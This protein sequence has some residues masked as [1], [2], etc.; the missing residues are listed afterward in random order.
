VVIE[1]P[2]DYTKK[3]VVPFDAGSHAPEFVIVRHEP[4]AGC[5]LV[6]MHMSSHQAMTR[7]LKLDPAWTVEE[8][9][10]K[11]ERSWTERD[12]LEMTAEEKALGS[13]LTKRALNVCLLATAYGVRKDFRFRP[14]VL[15]PAND[16]SAVVR[17]PHYHRSACLLF[18]HLPNPLGSRRPMILLRVNLMVRT[19][20]MT[21]KHLV[22][23][24]SAGQSQL[25]IRL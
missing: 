24:E 23:K 5:V 13:A 21:P 25:L 4:E 20:Q 7:L 22:Q 12:S 8:M 3:R 16:P 10:A 17:S 15:N 9:W 1:L 19:N 6:T 11:G 2:E 14:L 18:Q